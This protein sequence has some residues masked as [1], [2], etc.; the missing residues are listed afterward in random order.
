MVLRSNFCQNWLVLR[1]SI[2]IEVACSLI[3]SEPGFSVLSFPLKTEFHAVANQGIGLYSQNVYQN[4]PVLRS[5]ILIETVLTSHE[6]CNEFF[7]PFVLKTIIINH[8]AFRGT[9]CPVPPDH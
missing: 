4:Q 1:N 6:E 5:S 2:Y 8:F 7:G 9:L 3:Y